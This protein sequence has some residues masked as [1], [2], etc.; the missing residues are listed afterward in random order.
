MLEHRI[1]TTVTEDGSIEIRGLPFKPGDRVEVI[2]RPCG[3]KAPKPYSS[4]GKSSESSDPF[5]GVA[6]KDWESLGEGHRRG[7]VSADY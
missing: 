6:G 4:R 5:G 3:G 2:V 1:K 7:S